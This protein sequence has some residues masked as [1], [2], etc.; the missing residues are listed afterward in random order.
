MALATATFVFVDGHM[1]TSKIRIVVDANIELLFTLALLKH[2]VVPFPVLL[3]RWFR[4]DSFHLHHLPLLR[5][6]RSR[7]TL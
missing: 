4:Y 7:F 1:L 6:R 2:L 5:F 3:V